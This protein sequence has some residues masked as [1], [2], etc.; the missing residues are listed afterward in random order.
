MA[1][2]RVKNSYIRIRRMKTVLNVFFL[3][4]IPVQK[5][6]SESGRLDSTRSG[7]VT[8]ICDLITIILYLQVFN[9][10]RKECPD[11]PKKVVAVGGDITAEGL[12]LS[13]ADHSRIIDE[14]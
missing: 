4:S 9:V 1:S 2:K 6:T 5:F 7:I 8:L 13:A 10:L 12:G 11:F 3:R 14:V